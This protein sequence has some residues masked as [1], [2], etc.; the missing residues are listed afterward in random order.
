MLADPGWRANRPPPGRVR[1][2]VERVEPGLVRLHAVLDHGAHHGCGPNPRSAAPRGAARP[3]DWSEESSSS[4]ARSL[5]VVHRVGPSLDPGLQRVRHANRCAPR[6]ASRRGSR[7]L[8]TCRSRGDRAGSLVRRSS[9]TAAAGSSKREG[10][11]QSLHDH[12][13]RTARA[14]LG[15]SP[16]GLAAEGGPVVDVVDVVHDQ[17]AAAR[18]R[19]G[20]TESASLHHHPHAGDVLRIGAEKLAPG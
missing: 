18:S 5:S 4:A 11:G 14:P 13:R 16:G 20:E 17:L 9:A 8:V 3:R 10:V 12:G 7:G 6:A 19:S 15:G 1:D 2:L